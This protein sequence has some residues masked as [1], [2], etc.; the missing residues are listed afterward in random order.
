MELDPA[1]CQ[2]AER[3]CPGFRAVAIDRLAADSTTGDD[4]HKVAGY[5]VARRVRLVAADGRERSLAFHTVTAN[6]FG[7]D[8]RSDRAQ[9]QLD[10]FDTF[11]R[12]PKQVPALDV[13]AIGE[14]GELVSLRRAGELY[15][16]SGWAEGQPYADSLRRIAGSGEAGPRDGQLCEALAA[17][18]VELHAR[19]SP[20]PTR[21]RRAVRDLIGHGE[22][23]FGMTDA[24]PADTPGAPP[25]RLRAI[26][27]RLVNWRWRLRGCEA[28]GTTIHGDFHPFNVIVDASGGFSLLDA[29][30]GGFGDPAD[31][32]TAM[33]INY[34]FF[35]LGHPRG[36]SALGPLWHRFWTGYLDS[37]GD[38]ALLSVCAPWLAW[39]ALVVSSPVFYPA[40]P[41]PARDRVL[42]LAERAL[43]AERFE[44][45]WA[46]ELFA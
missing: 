7:H 11:G 46:D 17:Y 30:R 9:E 6:P 25:K 38:H 28:R 32:V 24:Y 13:G 41:G 34:V 18:L 40:L 12:I 27:E 15:L 43:D 39:R 19:P 29:S 14:S 44:L 33:A 5:G 4:T 3:L 42:T 37:S 8:R 45:A 31:D 10:A 26:E 21:Y 16:V 22:G 36:W 1:I 20:A 23:I 35:A 2:L